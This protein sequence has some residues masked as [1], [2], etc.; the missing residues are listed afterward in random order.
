MSIGNFDTERISKQTTIMLCALIGITAGLIIYSVIAPPPGKL[1]DPELIKLVP[2]TFAFCT[3]FV[4]REAVKEGLGVKYTHGE[5]TFEF[6][7]MDGKANKRI[8][9]ESQNE[10][11]DTVS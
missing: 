1:T 2:W 3:L 11:H 7:D 8:I 6:K 4:A 9:H 10:E 5:T